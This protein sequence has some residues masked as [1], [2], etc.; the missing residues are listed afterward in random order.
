MSLTNT[1]FAT[2]LTTLLSGH[3]TVSDPSALGTS[4]TTLLNSWLEGSI[5]T[6]ELARKLAETLG[7]W[8]QNQLEFKSWYTGTITGGPHSDGTYPLTNGVG[9]T[10]YFPSLAKLASQMQRGQD[11]AADVNLFVQGI[12]SPSELLGGLLYAGNATTF[13]VSRSRAKCTGAPTGTSVITITK[14][15]SSVGT[16]TFTSGSTTGTVALTNTSISPGDLL[17]FTAPSTYDASFQNVFITL[18]GTL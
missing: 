12:L 5:T 15:G 6:A 11:A 13:D 18:A 10:A 16:V 9:S 14:N 17:Q 4:L 1:E 7:Y 2:Q 3:L 8:N